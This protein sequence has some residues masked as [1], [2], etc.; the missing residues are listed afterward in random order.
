MMTPATTQGFQGVFGSTRTHTNSNDRYPRT[1]PRTTNL[2]AE[3]ITAE[4]TPSPSSSSS[5]ANVTFNPVKPHH[6]VADAVSVAQLAYDRSRAHNP[7]LPKADIINTTA[8]RHSRPSQHCD[9]PCHSQQQHPSN[10]VPLSPYHAWSQHSSYPATMSL[11]YE[12]RSS[13]MPESSYPQMQQMLQDHQ[14]QDDMHQE[15]HSRYP[16][17]PPP[18]SEN[19]YHPPHLDATPDDG[20]EVPSLPSHDDLPPSPSRSKP[21][22]KP[23]REVT[24]GPNGRFVCV[25][26]NCTEDIR[27]FGRK[28]S[29]PRLFLHLPANSSTV[30]VVEA[31]G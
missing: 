18:L 13:F 29:R 24:K 4:I 10:L 9:V 26:E 31:H 21:I 7:V 1:S 6:Q 2:T 8:S 16:S 25:Y 28:V 30:R 12:S 19:P 5:P 23:D 3:I 22:P 11:S 17:P 14:E 15:Q 27:D 20:M